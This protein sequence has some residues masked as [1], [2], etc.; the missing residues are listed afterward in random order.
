[1]NA[2]AL[3]AFILLIVGGL[4]WQAV[5]Q[6]TGAREPWDADAYWYLWYPISCLLSAIA[7]V[8]FRKTGWLAGGIITFSQL[9]ILWLNSGTGPLMA[10]GLLFLSMLAVPTIALSALTG[11]LAARGRS[12]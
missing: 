5:C 7:G 11:W 4:Y 8:S 3:R 1:M 10:V 12:A 2:V 6:M 9:P